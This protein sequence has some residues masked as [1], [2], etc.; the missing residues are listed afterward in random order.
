MQPPPSTA[1]GGAETRIRRSL[2]VMTNSLTVL[3]L[4][5]SL[6]TVALWVRSYRVRDLVGFGHGELS[7]RTV[8]PRPFAPAQQSRWRLHGRS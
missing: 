3:S 1:H 7:R 2:R 5:V 4:L 8:N 6:V